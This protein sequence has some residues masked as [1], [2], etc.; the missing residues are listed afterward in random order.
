MT[1]LGSDVLVCGGYNGSHYQSSCVQYFASI[2]MWAAIIP[3]MPV[4]INHFPLITLRSRPYVFGG[5]N[6]SSIL[7]TVYTFNTSNVWSALTP[8]EQPLGGHAAVALDTNTA[9]VCG[10]DKYGV[11]QS[12]CFTYAAA[13]DAWSAAPHLNTGRYY[14]G[15]AVYKGVR[16]L[17]ALCIIIYE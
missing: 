5:W 11:A 1:L 10:G 6:G 3:P 17:F 9:V 16:K 2:T 8:M 4:A 13:S 15:M 14:H 12:A 7:N